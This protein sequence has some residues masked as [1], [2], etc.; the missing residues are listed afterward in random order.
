MS[1]KQQKHRCLCFHYEIF[2]PNFDVIIDYPYLTLLTYL[3][4]LQWCR[5]WGGQGGHW[6]SQYLADQL[7][8]FQ[9][10][11]GRLS[12]PITTGPPKVFH[13]PASVV[14]MCSFFK[15]RFYSL[16]RL[17]FQIKIKKKLCSSKTLN[18]WPILHQF[19][20]LRW[21]VPLIYECFES[22]CCDSPH[23]CI[24]LRNLMVVPYN[25]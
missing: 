17:W 12:P 4:S 5:D 22:T 1:W 13:L 21:S 20:L 10:G 7:T 9:P 6:P 23:K 18:K 14:F 3:S 16:E 24:R 11:E 19:L 25:Y 15:W 2:W 8:P